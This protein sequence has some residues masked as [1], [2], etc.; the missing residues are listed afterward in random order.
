[1]GNILGACLAWLL[2]DGFMEVRH[3]GVEEHA[4]AWLLSCPSTWFR[5]ITLDDITDGV[6]TTS[7]NE[8]LPFNVLVAA[9]L[10]LL[11]GLISSNY[12]E[13]AVVCREEGL[14]CVCI[15]Y[16]PLSAGYTECLVIAVPIILLYKE[17]L[18]LSSFSFLPSNLVCVQS[19]VS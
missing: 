15:L 6:I 14:L 11:G 10:C 4:R 3:I 19:Q 1:M 7:I 2:T 12:L 8:Y 16:T 5:G 17:K 13:N 18:S 9:P